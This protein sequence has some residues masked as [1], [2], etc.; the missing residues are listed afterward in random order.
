MKTGIGAMPSAPLAI[1]FAD[2]SE[3]DD[4][5]I[6]MPVAIES[7]RP[8]FKLRSGDAR[9][10]GRISVILPRGCEDVVSFRAF[11]ESLRM[12][13]VAD[14]IELVLGPGNPER[15]LRAVSVLD[16]HFPGQYSFADI[17][18]RAASGAFLLFADERIVLHDPRTLEVLRYIASRDNVASAS[19]VLVRQASDAKPESVALYE[20]G[21]FSASS[22]STDG[23]DAVNFLPDFLQVFPA[24]TYPVAA[25]SRLLFM[26]RA[27]TWARIGGFGAG[28][29]SADGGNDPA[30]HETDET[31]VSLCTSIV[32]AGFHERDDAPEMGNGAETGLEPAGVVWRQA[33]AS[34]VRGLRG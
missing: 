32:S 12:Q 24:A 19:C 15:Q 26:T 22:C 16:S 7:G 31:L 4:A 11:L 28:G 5:G 1:R 8:L 23:N 3:R 20:G 17:A 25:N 2:M 34:V 21:V 33:R 9:E 29:P 30:A 18:D 14:R 27:D 10:D 13:T 6:L